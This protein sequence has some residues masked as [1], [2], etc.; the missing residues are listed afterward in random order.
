MMILPNERLTKS[1]AKAAG[2]FLK[3]KN[4]TLRSNLKQ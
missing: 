3:K 1:E 4:N 2:I